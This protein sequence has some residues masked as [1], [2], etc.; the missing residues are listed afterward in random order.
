MATG[1]DIIA[2][3]MAGKA[4][5][6]L[7]KKADLVNGKVPAEQL[8]SYIDDIIE[9]EDYQHLPMPGE[10]GKIY[11]TLDNNKSYRWSGSAYVEIPSLDQVYTKQETNALLAQKQNQLSAGDGIEITEEDVVNVTQIKASQVIYNK[12]TIVAQ[13]VGGLKTGFI[14]T[15]R[16]IE[17]I[18]ERLV[19]AYVPP[20]FTNTTGEGAYTVVNKR[21]GTAGGYYMGDTAALSNVTITIAKGTDFDGI[22]SGDVYINSSSVYTLSEEDINALNDGSVLELELSNAEY[23]FPANQTS[24]TMT[25]GVHLKYNK[26]SYD[27]NENIVINVTPLFIQGGELTVR[28][29][30]TYKKV[31][32]GAIAEGID[33]SNL[34]PNG[35]ITYGDYT[36]TLNNK[37]A[38][39]DVIITTTDEENC[40]VIISDQELQDIKFMTNSDIANWS[41][42]EIIASYVRPNSSV[43]TKNYYVY[44][45]T[46]A[47]GSFTYVLN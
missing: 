20:V 11:V 7:D 35:E 17:N 32:Y 5:S 25:Y 23:T 24:K 1:T 28:D 42:Q 3:G 43:F 36:K 16:T 4:I 9:I 40:G 47:T 22:V 34:S 21:T 6:A 37:N 41:K 14:L 19:G 33:V 39:G 45:R 31:Y 27:S 44:Y 46:M 12:N 30:A 10:A 38:L 26:K 29:S 15:G 18:L 2:R 13:D 8:P